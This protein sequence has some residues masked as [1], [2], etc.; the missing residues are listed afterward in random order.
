MAW[1]YML[2]V[3]SDPPEPS[4]LISQLRPF[5][6]VFLYLVP[7]LCVSPAARKGRRAIPVAATFWSLLDPSNSHDPS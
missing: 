5:S 6:T 2:L 4:L 1:A 7:N 3:P